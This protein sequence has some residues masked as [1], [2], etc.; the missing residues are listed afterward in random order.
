M[1]GSSQRK[2]AIRKKPKGNPTA[3]SGGRVRQGLEGRGPTPKAVDRTKHPAHKR[4]KAKERAEKRAPGGR[5]PDRKDADAT[6]EW[7]YGRNPVVEALRAGVPI[8]ALYVAEGTER[9]ARLRE[10]LL[11]ATEHGISL[12]EVPRTEMDRLTSHGAHQGLAVQIP[13][14][15]YAH[16]DDLL[17]RAYDAGQVPLIVAL[18]G[19]TDPRNLGAITRSAAAFG[20][21]G[22]LV[23]ER[24]TASMTASAWKTSAG[25]AARIPVARATNLNRA[26]KSYKDAGLMIVGLDMGGEVELPELEAA[27]EPIVLVVGSEGK[28]LA[29]LV[30][31]NCDLIV[32]IP[33]TSATESLNAGIA[34]GV[35]LYEISRRRA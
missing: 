31:E 5:R 16:P 25:A 24:R 12:L 8:N 18:D 3:G 26:L 28:G 10:A 2:G 6:V 14:Y 32:S 23:P 19:V 27:T 35:A 15:E 17:S 1:P 20:A 29:R 11:I 7:V 13:P 21:H 22:V 30:R 34:T 33:M 9:D 4:A